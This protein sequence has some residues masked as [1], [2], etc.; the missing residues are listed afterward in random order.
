MNTLK[1]R[2]AGLGV[3][4]MLTLPVS[5]Q[6]GGSQE[7]RDFKPLIG[8]WQI[9]KDGPNPM[10]AVNGSKWVQGELSPVARD[11]ATELYGEKGPNFL[12]NIA[13]YKAFPLSIYREVRN[14]DSGTLSVLFKAIGGKEDQAAGIAFNIRENGEYLAIRANALENN[15]ILFSFTNGRRSPLREVENV[16]TAPKQWHML[17]VVIK[18]KRVEGYL[19]DK[20]YL[21]YALKE[22][23]SGRIGLWSKSD[24]HVLFK[25]FMFQPK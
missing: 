15:L 20:I 10:Y 17:K 9:E 25:S 1:K 24:S 7:A 8:V 18:G 22:N 5:A 3:L 16:P 13:V 19:D 6:E 14:F 23:V 2:V 12:K 21:E 11:S 4:L